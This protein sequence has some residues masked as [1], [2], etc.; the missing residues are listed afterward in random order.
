[1][2]EE[3]DDR[4]L[5]QAIHAHCA[6]QCLAAERGGGIM[7]TAEQRARQR[8]YGKVARAASEL[9]AELDA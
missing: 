7:P 4:R 5:L 8:A 3:D 1:M 6:A 9:L 2:P